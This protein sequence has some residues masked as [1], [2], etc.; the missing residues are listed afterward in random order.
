MSVTLGHLWGGRLYIV[1]G[2]NEQGVGV[3][4]LGY[5][6]EYRPRYIGS[7]IAY[8]LV[9][10]VYDYYTRVF[11]VLGRKKTCKRGYIPQLGLILIV[12]LC[13]PCLPSHGEVGRIEAL[14]GPVLDGILQ[15][16][17]DHLGGLWRTDGAIEHLYVKFL[18][19][20]IPLLHLAYH[21]WLE[22][23]P[24]VGNSIVEGE[25]L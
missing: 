20:L 24:I 16:L 6:L 3:Y 18:Y 10:V 17:L 4:L 15:Y 5:T 19:R 23:Y 2:V 25:H 7:I 21:T 9:R 22:H 12:F 8:L 14:S 13:R 1:N 11:R